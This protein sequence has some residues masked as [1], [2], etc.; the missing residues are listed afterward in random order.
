MDILNIEKVKADDVFFL[1]AGRVHYIGKGCLLAEIQQSSDVTYRIYDFDR[2]DDK[3][4]AVP[5]V[6][7]HIRWRVA[8]YEE[9][10]RI[11]D[12][13]TTKSDKEGETSVNQARAAIK[14]MVF[15]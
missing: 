4:N 14:G 5:T 2:K 1:P 8:V 13:A 15:K 11:I 9:E 7:N 10:K 12:S 6:I 3:G